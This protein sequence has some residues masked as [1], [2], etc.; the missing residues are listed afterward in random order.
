MWDLP[1]M[2]YLNIGTIRGTLYKEMNQPRDFEH[3][4][5]VIEDKQ[6][7]QFHS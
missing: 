5:G 4:A 7:I 1:K 2:F 6:Q 3:P